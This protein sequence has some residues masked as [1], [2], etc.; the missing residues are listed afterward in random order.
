MIGFS[1]QPSPT[2]T[3]VSAFIAP[4]TAVRASIAI[5]A[6]SAP[7]ARY[8]ASTKLANVG[9]RTSTGK[10]GP[11]NSAY[12]STKDGSIG[13]AGS[14]ALVDAGRMLSGDLPLPNSGQAVQASRL[15][16]LLALHRG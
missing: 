1:H 13:V 14:T 2:R 6:G 16:P 15:S 4:A 9:G 11:T 8:W 10:T 12:G 7:I 5:A 3:L